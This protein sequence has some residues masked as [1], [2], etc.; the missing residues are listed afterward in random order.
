METRF[1][2]DA[3]GRSCPE[4]M[5]LTAKALTDFA[6]KELEVLVDTAVARDNVRRLATSRGLAVSVEDR[7]DDWAVVIKR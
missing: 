1:S 7:G 5:V 4:P 2:V 6:G 3:R